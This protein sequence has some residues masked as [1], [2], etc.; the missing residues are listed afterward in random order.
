METINPEVQNLFATYRELI[1]SP[2][3]QLNAYYERLIWDAH[4]MGL[5]PESLIAVFLERKKAIREGRSAKG[6]FIRHLFG[7]EATGDVLDEAANIE[8]RK[9]IRLMDHN[10]ASVLRQTG[11]NDA[12]PVTEAKPVSEII[13]KLKAL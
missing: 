12:A 11:R 8:G 1:G 13:Q 5:T 7:E 2:G 10:K 9:R 4:K 3:L 6:T